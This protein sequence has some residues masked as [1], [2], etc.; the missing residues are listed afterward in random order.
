MTTR[1]NRSDWESIVHRALTVLRARPSGIV[2]DFDGT[3]SPIVPEPDRAQ[4]TPLAIDALRR[5]AGQIDLVAV[6]TGR[7]AEDVMRRLNVPRIVVVGNHGA[8][9]LVDGRSRI[10][11][12]VERWIPILR[13]AVGALQS[14]LADLSIEDK[15]LSLA[16]HLR[17]VS[18]VPL[19]QRAREAV[20]RIAREYGLRVR[21]GR[22]VLEVLPPISVDKGTAVDTLVT[23]GGLR[24]VIFAGDD[25]T[26]LDAMRR[27][28]ELRAAR[29]VDAL[30]LGIWSDE[31][32]AELTQLADTLLSGA[33]EFAALLDEVSKRSGAHHESSSGQ[34][35]RG[36]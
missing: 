31:A 22:E 19:R 36:S 9:W 15:G 26:D 4:P 3:L 7:R 29:A 24:G 30:V 11:P 34:M 16:V 1:S 10:V 32:P 2:T 21:S 27:V 20:E 5:L 8:E 28:R 23:T 25:V 33:D 12:D 17:G 14:S 18:A 13:T 35:G 6:V